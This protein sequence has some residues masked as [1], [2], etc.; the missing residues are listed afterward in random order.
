MPPIADFDLRKGLSLA[1]GRKGAVMVVHPHLARPG[2]DERGQK[3]RIG[4]LEAEAR[5]AAS[6]AATWVAYRAQQ[7]RA[8][9]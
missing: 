8:A 5:K 7:P 1:Q 3:A 9:A 4:L 2:D 6:I